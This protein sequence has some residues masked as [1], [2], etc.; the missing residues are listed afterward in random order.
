[1]RAKNWFLIAY[2]SLLVLFGIAVY[3]YFLMLLTQGRI[4]AEGS[5]EN[6]LFADFIN[7]YNAGLLSAHCVMHGKLNIYDPAVQDAFKR[8]FLGDSYNPA[9]P[10]YLQ[11]PPWFF[12]LAMPLALF[13][14]HGGFLFWTAAAIISLVVS[15]H[16]LLKQTSFTSNE[17]A[18][19]CLAIAVSFPVW[20]SLRMGQTSLFNF[21][22]VV[23]FLAL[24][25][26]RRFILAGLAASFITVKLQYAPAF[27]VMGACLGGVPFALGMVGGLGVM[28]VATVLVLGMQNVTGYPDA[29]RI[30]E[31][32]KLFGV[33]PERMQ[34][35]RGYLTLFVK[36]A[37]AMKI[38]IGGFAAGLCGIGW[39]WSRRAA[40]EHRPYQFKF[41]VSIT[42][43]IIVMTSLH[44]HFY[45]YVM[46]IISC[47]WLYDLVR[48]EPVV[49]QRRAIQTLI[50]IAPFGGWFAT[51]YSPQLRSAFIQP[52]FL[53]ALVL[54]VLAA[55]VWVSRIRNNASA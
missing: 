4:F 24:L 46:M 28:M 33:W 2:V 15:V 35:I 26:A 34:N 9:A 45:D 11:Y 25:H 3:A 6:S 31:S 29:L 17:K 21:A 7:H 41:M 44:T 22:A 37:V 49:W 14:V 5:G 36:P 48:D 23:C 20:L 54:T 39:V 52:F 47:I 43:A 32:T 16:W 10:F 1:M 38:G 42:M 51:L 27:F 30:G 50:L 13:D 55:R 8:S 12:V 19:A 53:W 40:Q 18:I